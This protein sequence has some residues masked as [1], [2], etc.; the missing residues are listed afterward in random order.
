MVSCGLQ[1]VGWVAAAISAWCFS[2]S[3][4]SQ[5]SGAMNV[6]ARGLGLEP[7]LDRAAQLRLVA[8]PAREAELG[9]PEAERA[10]A[11]RAASAG[12]AAAR[13]RR[14]GSRRP[15]DAARAARRARCSAASAATSRSSG[16]ASL[17][18]SASIGRDNLT[19][20]YV[21]VGVTVAGG[22]HLALSDSGRRDDLDPVERAAAE[23]ARP[24][25][26]HRRSAAPLPSPA[27]T[28]R[29]R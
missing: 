2:C 29:S 26:L 19:T 7:L 17:I 12:A 6:G 25:R 15:S 9:E 3:Q 24:R 18:V 13:A 16:A 22:A 21:N 8:Q 4:R 11:A 14:G 5:S 27:A 28:A 20:A 10:P 1:L 23:R